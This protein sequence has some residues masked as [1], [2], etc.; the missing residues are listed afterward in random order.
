MIS[1]SSA[2]PAPRY[3]MV[4][5]DFDGT[6]ADSGMWFLDILDEL[7]DRFKFRKVREEEIEIFRGMSSRD[8]ISAVKIPF[9]K[10][11]AMSKY[12]RA[13]L[14]GEIEKIK[15]F[16]GIAPAIHALA[17]AGVRLA[18]VSSN[19]VENVHAVLGAELVARIERFECGTSLFG[20]D[21]RFKRIVKDSGLARGAILAIGDE[22]RDISAARK[23][24]IDA[25]A[26]LWGYANETVLTGMRPDVALSSP[27]EIVAAV[28]I[29][30]TAKAA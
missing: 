13:R 21:A 22:T 14:A 30:A 26:V 27:G 19:S 9:W 12:V 7:S 17:D 23:V 8:V 11:P 1:S 24:G 2:A 15:L 28:G 3:G 20:K 5:F 25:G 10:L 29:G 4:I 18:V 6:L 16:D